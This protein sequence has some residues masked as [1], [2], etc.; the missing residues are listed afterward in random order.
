VEV[1]EMRHGQ[2]AEAEGEVRRVIRAA[3]VGSPSPTALG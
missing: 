1:S 2:D 3:E